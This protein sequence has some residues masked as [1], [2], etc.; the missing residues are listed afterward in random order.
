[1][2]FQ[3]TYADIVVFSILDQL[4]N[5]DP[6]FVNSINDFL[7]LKNFCMRMSQLP[8][9]AQ[10]LLHRKRVSLLQ[11]RHHTPPVAEKL[12][13]SSLDRRDGPHA[14]GA[15]SIGAKP[16]RC[17]AHA[18]NRSISSAYQDADQMQILN[19]KCVVVG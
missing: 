12:N 19:D 4:C 3:L 10:Y 11:L 9:I 13:R 6:D 15:R 1:M 8:N 7:A 2:L 14:S 5:S 18:R 16:I 17:F